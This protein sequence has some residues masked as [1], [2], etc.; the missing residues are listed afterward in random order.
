M[1]TG[2]P[3]QLLPPQGSTVLE[4]DTDPARLSKQVGEGSAPALAGIPLGARLEYWNGQFVYVVGPAEDAKIVGKLNTQYQW[5][6]VKEVNM[7]WEDWKEMFDFM[8]T[9]TPTGEQFDVLSKITSRTKVLTSE[10]EISALR[11][12][13]NL[14]L[15]SGDGHAQCMATPTEASAAFTSGA[16]IL[17]ITSDNVT[18]PGNVC[19]WILRAQ[20]ASYLAGNHNV[21]MSFGETPRS[22]LPPGIFW[23]DKS[24]ILVVTGADGRYVPAVLARPPHY[25]IGSPDVAMVDSALPTD[26]TEHWVEEVLTDE[27]SGIYVYTE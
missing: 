16:T 17:E 9:Y 13:P 12:N 7:T 27:Y 2:D 20:N 8:Y 24:D 15:L 23:I 14:I 21:S 11:G 1:E 18:T 4:K 10:A 5:E 22:P 26:S 3:D 19:N 6:V 25:T